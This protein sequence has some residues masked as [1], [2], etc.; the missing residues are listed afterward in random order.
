M[1]T[2]TR[3]QTNLE[4]ALACAAQDADFRAHVLEDG[5]EAQAEY[6]LTDGE[7]HTLFAAVERLE[8]EL[9][10][11][12]LVATEV[13]HGEADAAALK[14]QAPPAARACPFPCVGRRARLGR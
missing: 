13:D 4:W 2:R 5:R 8:Q 1:R 6:A 12:P 14:G 9:A 11:D 7:W 3:A 10:R